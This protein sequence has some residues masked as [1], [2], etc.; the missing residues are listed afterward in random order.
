VLHT[1][2]YTLLTLV[3]HT[4]LPTFRAP[5]LSAIFVAHFVKFTEKRPAI[6][7]SRLPN[8]Q[9]F[10]RETVPKITL[11]TP[12]RT[13]QKSAFVL[14]DLSA[15]AGT[16]NRENNCA[17]RRLAITRKAVAAWCRMPEVSPWYPAIPRRGASRVH[18]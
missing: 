12:I 16:S 7:T 14:G 2:L 5:S 10:H 17:G 13:Q 6:R 18:G 9:L 3:L 4:L 11:A 15:K 1:L 8:W